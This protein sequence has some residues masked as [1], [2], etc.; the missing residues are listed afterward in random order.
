[1]EDY[2]GDV[3]SV[4][5][6]ART[7]EGIENLLGMILFVAE[8]GNYKANPNRAATG[9]VI[10]AK[11]DKARGPVATVLV[12]HGTLNVGDVIVAGGYAGRI[13][14]LFNDKGKRIR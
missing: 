4:P 2:G 3:E 12:D 14:A 8:M 13:K 7:G 1:V 6:S 5:V 11:L 10:E 9:S